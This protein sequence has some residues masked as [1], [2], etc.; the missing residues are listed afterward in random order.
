M[1]Q[2]NRT[3][4]KQTKQKQE[5]QYNPSATPQTETPLRILQKPFNPKSYQEALL[6]A[7]L[8]TLQEALRKLSVSSQGALQKALRRHLGTLRAILELLGGRYRIGGKII[9]VICDLL[10]KVARQSV[11][12]AQERRDMHEVLK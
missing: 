6:E 12:P 5:N 2:Q 9:R 4:R 7:L 8:E 3:A 10:S 11:S 1:K